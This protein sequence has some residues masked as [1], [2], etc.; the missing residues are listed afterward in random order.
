MPPAAEETIRQTGGDL[1]SVRRGQK[2]LLTETVFARAVGTTL[3]GVFLTALVRS[4]G[5][6]ALEV[7][8]TLAAGHI[9]ALGML[10]AN[11]VLNHIGSRRR[12]CLITLG[13]V[14]SLRMVIAAMPL[15]LYLGLDRGSLLWPMV[16]CVLVSAFFGMS[17]EISRRS[18]I[19][20]LVGP[21]KRGKFLGRRVMIA[22]ITTLLIWLGGGWFLDSFFAPPA[23]RLPGLSIL[24]GF[25]GLM[26]WLGWWLLL[27]TP[28]P[29]L[30]LPRR[31]TGFG[32]SLALPWLRPRFRPVVIV[33]TASAL[34]TGVCGGFFHLYM[35]NHL[36]M[37]VFWIAGVDIVGEL[38]ALAGAP[39]YGAWADRA[40]ARRV[41]A[42]SML[43]K[44]VFPALWILVSPGVW[45]LAFAV[46]LLRT[47]NSAGQ[48]CWL[49]LSL[50][51]SPARNQVAFLAMHQAL[52]G[53]GSAVGALV[54]G[55][56]ARLLEP[57]DLG[58]I[59]G[60]SIVPLHVLFAVSAVLR[61]S[62]VVLVRLIREPRR[63]L[64]PA[65]ESQLP[66]QSEWP[67]GQE[68]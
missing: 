50:N 59:G 32:R 8:A 42:V 23:D 21:T 66:R 11:P 37:K 52:M 67:N 20:D 40:G 62:S 22:S 38:V 12:F 1:P 58:S 3:G 18:W 9:G 47:F 31:P 49:R 44:G 29:P 45:P 28:E 56:T 41:L 53:A 10:L 43:V 35:L 6:G 24:I 46:V 27:R 55:T 4:L 5:G 57:F 39:F 25:G 51:L 63:T 60:I 68:D 61:L 7:G 36:G 16:A 19:S 13:A 64:R 2:L 26:G 30:S 48:I 17:A 65:A 34:A 33:G 15:L 54:G 14:R